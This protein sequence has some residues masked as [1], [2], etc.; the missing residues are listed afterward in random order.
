MPLGNQDCI[1]AYS[2]LYLVTKLIT[3]RQKFFKLFTHE[4][5]KMESSSE[6]G[7]ARGQGVKR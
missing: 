4:A 5:V 2:H 6:D 7:R 1:G 3:T